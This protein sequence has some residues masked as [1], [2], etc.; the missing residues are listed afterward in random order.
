ML[1][2][3][4]LQ[5][6]PISKGITELCVALRQWTTSCGTKWYKLLCENYTKVSAAFSNLRPAYQQARTAQ[7]SFLQPSQ[8]LRLRCSSLAC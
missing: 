6:D 8:P 2:P 1:W 5:W 4:M 7:C 3:S